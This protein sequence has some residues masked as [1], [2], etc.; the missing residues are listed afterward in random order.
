MDP[1]TSQMERMLN[2]LGK[3]HREGAFSGDAARYPWR[4][5]EPEVASLTPRRFAWA[6]VA[7]PL[8]AAAAV[9]VLFLGPPLWTPQAVNEVAE[10]T[11]D[12]GNILKPDQPVVVQPVAETAEAVDCDYNGDGQV[13]GRDIQA[14]VDSLKDTSG[15][16]NLEVEYLQ[17]C[18]LGD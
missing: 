8:A 12:T 9:A 15:D 7:V 11:L 14:F 4:T 17:R 6:R 1:E 2:L 5:A 3:A 10:G 18:L 13:D 16:P